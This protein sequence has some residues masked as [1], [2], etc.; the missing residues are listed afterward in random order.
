MLN[1]KGSYADT[2]SPFRAWFFF[3]GCKLNLYFVFPLY[4]AP[5]KSTTRE[6]IFRRLWGWNWNLFWSSLQKWMTIKANAAKQKQL[7]HR[8]RAFR[9]DIIKSK[10]WKPRIMDIKSRTEYFDQTK[11]TFLDTKLLYTA[12]RISC[13]AS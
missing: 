8:Q 13:S 12:I 10:T 1:P 3:Q 9:K 6:Q 11:Q 2:L 4:R 7:S 5:R